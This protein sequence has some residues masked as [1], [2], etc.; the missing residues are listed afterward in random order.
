MLKL[1]NCERDAKGRFVR[2]HRPLTRPKYIYAKYYPKLLCNTCWA[3]RECA[4]YQKN[5]VCVHK[6]PY[7]QYESRDVDYVLEAMTDKANYLS[8]LLQFERIREIT[9]GGL[10]LPEV[11]RLINRN[12]NL[13]VHL[14]KLHQQIEVSET[15][16]SPISAEELKQII[17]LHKFGFI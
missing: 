8:A 9:D 4:E 1:Q 15:V 3:G 10:I 17:Q 2:G 12:F 13:A 5:C 7:N 16:E 11:S 6:K 14:L